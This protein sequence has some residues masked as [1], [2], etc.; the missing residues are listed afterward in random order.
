M[1]A[2]REGMVSAESIPEYFDLQVSSTQETNG[3]KPEQLEG[4]GKRAV[5][6]SQEHLWIVMIEL[7]EGFVYLSVSPTDITRARVEAL[8]KSVAA[9]AKK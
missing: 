7:D 5:L 3:S 1:K 6:F 2:I 9:H 8:A 4:I